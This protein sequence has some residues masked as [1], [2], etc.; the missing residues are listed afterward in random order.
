MQPQF[1]QYCRIPKTMSNRISLTAD[2]MLKQEVAAKTRLQYNLYFLIIDVSIH[3][4]SLQCIVQNKRNLMDGQGRRIL[5][6]R[7]SMRHEESVVS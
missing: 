7:E 6:R 3:E 1:S 4:V 2:I 5:K